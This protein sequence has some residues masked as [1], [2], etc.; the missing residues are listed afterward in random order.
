MARIQVNARGGQPDLCDRCYKGPEQECSRCGRVRP[1]ARVT[2]GEPICRTCYA[3]DER[4]LV[5][6]PLPPGQAGQRLLADRA[7]LPEL[8]HRHRPGSGG[9][10]P[11]RPGPPADRPRRVRRGDLRALCR[12][13]R[14]LHVPPV[15]AIGE[16]LR[17]RPLRLLRSRRQGRPAARGPGRRRRPEFQPGLFHRPPAPGPDRRGASVR[18][19]QHQSNPRGGRPPAG[20]NTAAL[21]NGKTDRHGA[22]HRVRL[23]P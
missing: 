19:R 15:R 6:R 2:S 22:D 4:P 7:G 10:R 3:R 18:P 17:S 21:S 8:L 20:R 13:R 5:T 12:I 1:C 16:P 9:V 11:L 14:R 23:A